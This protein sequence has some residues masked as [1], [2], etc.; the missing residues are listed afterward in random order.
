MGLKIRTW[1]DPQAISPPKFLGSKQLWLWLG[2]HQPISLVQLCSYNPKLVQDSLLDLWEAFYRFSDDR[3]EA[4]GLGWSAISSGLDIYKLITYQ[5]KSVQI[6]I[7]SLCVLKIL[8]GSCSVYLVYLQELSDVW[9]AGRQASAGLHGHRA[10]SEAWLPAK[11]PVLRGRGR[12]QL[13]ASASTSS[14]SVSTENIQRWFTI[15]LPGRFQDKETGVHHGISWFIHPCK[16]NPWK[17]FFG[18]PQLGARL[19]WPSQRGRG[20]CD[21][22]ENS[23]MNCCHRRTVTICDHSSIVYSKQT[24]NGGRSDNLWDPCLAGQLLDSV[25]HCAERQ[26]L[27]PRSKVDRLDLRQCLKRPV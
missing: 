19:N 9:A 5:Y 8:S 7:A 17:P 10:A 26:R 27:H 6:K 23:G 21:K 4:A 12:L 24:K 15:G 20:Q 1:G 22:P 11:L 14:A 2:P 18:I 16:G 13:L 3:L 25:L